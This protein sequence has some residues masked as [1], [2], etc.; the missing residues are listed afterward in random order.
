M[1]EAVAE[2]LG[3]GTQLLVDYHAATHALAERDT[4]AAPIPR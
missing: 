4:G 2:G 1:F 3:K